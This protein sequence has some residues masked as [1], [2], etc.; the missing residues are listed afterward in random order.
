MNLIKVF[1]TVLKAGGI[2]LSENQGQLGVELNLDI[3]FCDLF[4]IYFLVR[5]YILEIE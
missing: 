4:L 5:L 3:F 2:K 1:D